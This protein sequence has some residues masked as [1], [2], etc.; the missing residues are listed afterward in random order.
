[1]VAFTLLF[2]SCNQQAQK[3]RQQKLEELNAYVQERQDSVDNYLD[4]NW[5]ELNTEFEQ[6]RAELAKDTAQ[7]DDNLRWSYYNA[8]SKWQNFQAAYNT[9]YEEHK[10]VKEMD[11]LRATLA[12]PGVRQDYTDL[13]ASRLVE[14]YEHFVN[15]VEAHKD[16]Y[17]ADQWQVINVNYKALNGRK[18]EL[19]S[20]ITAPI[21]GKITKEQLRYTAIKA[22]NR[23]IAENP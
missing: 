10:R 16:E 22:V 17:T 12:L 19:E 23:P 15:I 11:A 20:Q 7:M 13:P 5:D 9:K 18:R 1:M 6:R 3:E 8:V 2:S 4:R 14:Q 21:G